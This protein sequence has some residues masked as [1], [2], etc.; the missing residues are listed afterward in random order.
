MTFSSVSV[1]SLM[2]YFEQVISEKVL[3]EVQ[4][5]YFILKEMEGIID[6]TPSYASI[7]VQFNCLCYDHQTLEATIRTVVS[8]KNTL[9]FKKRNKSIQIPTNYEKNLDL[10]RVAAYH[11]LSTEEVIYYHTQRTYRVYAIGFLVGFAYLASVDAHIT[12]PRLETPRKR[13][14]KG[15]VALA[16]TQTAIYPQDSAGGWNIIGETQFNDFH[17]FEIGDEVRFERI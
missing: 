15:A 7:L 10:Q 14:P 16:D 8:K 11:N 2:L 4:H 3:D 12:T 1:D 6:L 5:V 17:T 13:V 9:Q